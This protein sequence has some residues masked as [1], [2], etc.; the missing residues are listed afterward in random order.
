MVERRPGVDQVPDDV[1]MTE[2]RRG[3][4][5]SAVV[6]AGDVRRAVPS[7]RTGSSV[8]TSSRT[9]AMYGVV[10]LAVEEGGIG[11]RRRGA[12]GAVGA[13]TLGR[14][15]RAAALRPLPS[16]ALR[17]GAGRRRGAPGWASASSRAAAA[18][19]SSVGGNLGRRRRDLGRRRTGAC[20]HRGKEER[21]SDRLHVGPRCSPSHVCRRRAACPA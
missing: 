7:A 4:E 13:V 14:R 18:W 9:A 16:R 15:R 12:S 10:A 17:S 8:A 2:M 5:G 1:H 6:R 11:A 3:D 20:E 21:S 19:R